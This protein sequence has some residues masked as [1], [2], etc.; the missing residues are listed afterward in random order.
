[1]IRSLV[2]GLYVGAHSSR[3]QGHAAAHGEA[4]FIAKKKIT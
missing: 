2:A 1:M 4:R 3:F